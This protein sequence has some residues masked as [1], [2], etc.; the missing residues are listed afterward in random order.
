MTYWRVLREANPELMRRVI[1]L[2]SENVLSGGG[3]PFAALIVK[4][5]AV[6]AEA[7]NTVF[8]TNDPTAHGEVNAIRNACAALGAFSL[9]GC[10]IYSSSEPCPMCLAAI[11]WAHLDAIYFGNSCE[12][13]ARAGF[14][15]ADI[16]RELALERKARAVPSQQLL[17][18]EAAESF[19]LWDV[20]PNKQEY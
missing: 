1:R 16:F 8:T 5:G 15:D 14:D 3:G 6:I 13:A 10:E 11:Y 19:R 12:E 2:A 4:D 9:A 17:R 7:V 20:S 18:D